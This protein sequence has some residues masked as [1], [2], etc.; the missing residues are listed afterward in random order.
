MYCF[1]VTKVAKTIVRS[2]VVGQKSY[3]ERSTGGV[4][5]VYKPVLLLK[6]AVCNRVGKKKENK[7][8]KVIDIVLHNVGFLYGTVG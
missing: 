8:K 4:C 3:V 2:L 5:S 1:F 6:R 7:N